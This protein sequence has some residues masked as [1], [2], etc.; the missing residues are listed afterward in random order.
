MPGTVVDRERNAQKIKDLLEES[1]ELQEDVDEFEKEYQFR[2][3]LASARKETGL[4]QK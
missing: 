2:K 3:K 4:T 1:P